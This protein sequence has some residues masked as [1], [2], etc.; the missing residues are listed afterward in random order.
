MVE[1]IPYSQRIYQAF[2]LQGPQ[3]WNFVFENSPSANSALQFGNL[4]IQAILI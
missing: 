3:N 2:S 4:K 1:Y